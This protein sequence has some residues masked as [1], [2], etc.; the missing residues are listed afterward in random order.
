VSQYS[1][2][3]FKDGSKVDSVTTSETSYS[4]TKLATKSAYRFAVKGKNKAGWSK[5]GPQSAPVVPFGRPMAP[6]KPTASIDKGDAVVSWGAAD[7]NGSPVTGYTVESSNGSQMTTTGGRSVKFTGLPD[8][9]NV[10]FTVKA[11][12]AGGTSDPSPASNSVKPFSAPGAPSVSW[13]QTSATDGRFNVSG[14]G[15]WNGQSGTV[16]WSLSGSERKSGTGT[17]N[18]GVS[19]GYGKSYTLQARACN[20]AGCSAWRSASGKTDAPPN[21]T[22]WTSDSG[23]VYK[24]S[25][26]N[27]NNC[28]R[29]RVHA[30][31]DV[32]SGTYSFRCWNDR[33]GPSNF[34]TQTAYLAAGGY[35]D[36]YCVVGIMNGANVWATV[37]GKDWTFQKRAWPR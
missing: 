26:C 5:A 32:P 27:T 15:S 9:G 30:N 19:G 3:V 14:P 28:T 12:N 1:V 37:D 16:S 22:I 18:V 21:P 29:V 36:L 10:S 4:F 2:D 33:N 11:T 7:G 34:S 13:T 24:V 6:S 35:A 8:G 17:G 31:A 23:R 25:G 20:D